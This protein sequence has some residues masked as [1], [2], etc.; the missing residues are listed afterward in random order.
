M[1]FVIG[2]PDI[3]DITP[4][5]HKISIIIIFFFERMIDFYSS[6]RNYNI[7]PLGHVW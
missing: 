1:F 5:L 6:S 3:V 2:I 4:V 7:I